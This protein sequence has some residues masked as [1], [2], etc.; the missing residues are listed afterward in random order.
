LQTV[1][2]PTFFST[3]AR[4]RPPEMAAPD[5]RARPFADASAARQ[6]RFFHFDGP[7]RGRISL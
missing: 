7:R 6:I 3:R 4:R 2:A 1:G 5:R